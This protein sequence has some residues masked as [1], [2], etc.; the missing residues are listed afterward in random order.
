MNYFAVSEF[1]P[2]DTT[3][4]DV[5]PLGTS[6][7]VPT[8]ITGGSVGQTTGTNS[9]IWNAA[10]FAG[11]LVADVASGAITSTA[12]T[13]TIT[14]S[15]VANIGTYSHEFNVVVTAVSGTNPTLDISVQ[16]SPD[17]GANW[18]TIYE[19]ERITAQGVYAS[20]LIRAQFGTRFRYVQT[21]GG[22]SPSFTRAINRVQFS[23]PG[24]MVRR[25]MD[26]SIVLTTLNS[27]TPTYLVDGC[28][29]IE[30]L[31]NIGAATTP[32]TIQLQG[33]EDGSNW[34]AIGSA[35]AAV[36]SST[37]RQVATNEMPK[38]VRAVVSSAGSAVTAG[39]VCIKGTG[40]T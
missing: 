16:E 26:R 35:L 1:S 15:S 31:I 29:N 12:T 34:Y 7:S 8:Q 27:T 13:S 4:Q 23:A 9:T 38:F 6:T 18:Y 10:G 30:L 5:R 17:N 20:P 36:A 14:P 19:F 32:P 24:Q 40:T 37:V 25:F 3:I 11:F 22:T 28:G 39:Y 2:L 33:S 21:V